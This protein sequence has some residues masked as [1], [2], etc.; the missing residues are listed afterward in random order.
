MIAHAVYDENGKSCNG[1]GG[2]QTGK[3]ICIWDWYKSG[4]GWTHVLRAKDKKAA[5]KI[6][7][8]A[9]AIANNDNIGYDQNNRTSLYDNAVKVNYDI[10]KIK[11]PCECDCSTLVSV[12]VN[13][14]GVKIAKN[15]YTGNQLNAIKATDAFEILTDKK[16]LTSADNLQDG[17][18]LLRVGHT[19]VA[20][21]IRRKLELTSPRM[22]G[23]D[24]KKLQVLINEEPDGIYG[25][26]TDK[27]VQAIK[28]ALGL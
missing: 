3:E 8:T 27:K 24:V 4:S 14:A 25:P 28:A 13:A 26:D 22:K 10:S 19:A 2:D 15:I 16:Y 12:C 21:D 9:Q 7:E 23:E 17:D 5:K 1:V 20:V 18:I 6:S 11:V